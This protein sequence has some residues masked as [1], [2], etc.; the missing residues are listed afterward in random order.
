MAG[1][2]GSSSD[3]RN[4]PPVDKCVDSQSIC[5]DDATPLAASSARLIAFLRAAKRRTSARCGC[6]AAPAAALPFVPPS[7]NFIALS[8]PRRRVTAPISG[9]QFPLK[10]AF[11]PAKC[12]TRKNHLT[13][14]IVRR[15]FARFSHDE[16]AFY[17]GFCRV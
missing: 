17:E 8:P 4:T 7:R 10:R 11:P 6:R 12:A 1:Q 15:R 14:V 16:A 5:C 3:L 13:T 2:G 9:R